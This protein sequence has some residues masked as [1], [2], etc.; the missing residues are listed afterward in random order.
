MRACDSNPSE[1]RPEPGVTE[2]GGAEETR[3]SEGRPF[4][5][6]TVSRDGESY[7]AQSCYGCVESRSLHGALS[8]LA[9]GITRERVRAVHNFGLGE[10]E[11]NPQHVQR[12]WQRLMHRLGLP[13]AKECEEAE[14]RKSN[15]AQIAE[16]R[17]S[18]EAAARD[19]AEL[20]DANNRL[21]SALDCLARLGNGEH[22]GNS[23]GNLI[24]QDALGI[25]R[26]QEGGP[27]A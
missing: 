7:Y 20:E 11:A 19:L 14:S 18:L 6:I 27:D 23:E 22:Y 9:D 15:R 26:H 21:T 3:P 1:A 10:V 24:A 16:L 5:E 2:T 12:L 25:V 4:Y 8:T 17:E 13:T